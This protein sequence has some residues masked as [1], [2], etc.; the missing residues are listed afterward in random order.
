[1]P[2]TRA[3]LLARLRNPAYA[4][5]GT[6]KTILL[7]GACCAD[8]RE[9]ATEI[10]RLRAALKPFAEIG[11][12]LEWDKIPDDSPELDDHIMEAPA[13]DIAPK[14]VYCLMVRAFREAAR[15]VADEQ[16]ES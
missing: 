5:E 12:R 3:D 8:M 9:A 10:E 13:E 15:A 6:Q 11:R 4:I 1:M 7:T 14:A 2:V 16:R